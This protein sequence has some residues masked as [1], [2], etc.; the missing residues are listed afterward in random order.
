MPERVASEEDVVV[1]I[2]DF[3]PGIV[4]PK[5]RGPASGGASI[6]AAGAAQP[7]GTQ[8]CLAHVDG[9]IGPA[10]KRMRHRTET[11]PTFTTYRNGSGAAL[12]ASPW[13]ATGHNFN[14]WGSTHRPPE[15]PYRWI[16]ATALHTPGYDGTGGV[17]VDHGIS[18][19]MILATHEFF[20]ARGTSKYY[21]N[22]MFKGWVL[23]SPAG[24]RTLPVDT[25]AGV[26]WQ[27]RFSTVPDYS[28]AGPYAQMRWPTGDLLIGWNT[29]STATPAN[30]QV[31]R[32]LFWRAA[33]YGVDYRPYNGN[34]AWG[35]A[36]TTQQMDWFTWG[37]PDGLTLWATPNR[38]T[39]ASNPL[40]GTSNAVYH[41]FRFVHPSFPFSTA[42][43]DQSNLT[44]G[45]PAHVIR[46]PIFS[47]VAYNPA[48]DIVDD[49]WAGTPPVY[50]DKNLFGGED[51]GVTGLCSV[52]AS[53]LFVTQ[54]N[55]G[56]TVIRGDLDKS[57]ETY[58]PAVPPT[59]T[60]FS[61]PVATRKG[62]VY[63][64]ASGCHVWNEGS[65]A[66]TLSAN[67]PPK[68]WVTDDGNGTYDRAFFSHR[69]GKLGAWGKFVFV[70]NDWFCDIDSG[71]WWRMPDKPNPLT[72]PYQHYE[73]SPDGHLY[74]VPAYQSADSDTLWCRYDM[75]LY[76]DAAGESW[77][78]KSHP[79]P[80][81]LDSRSMICREIKV[82]ASGR[83]SLEFVVEGGDASSTVTFDV[84][85]HPQSYRLDAAVRNRN[86]TRGT[87]W[88]TTLSIVAT[89]DG[90]GPLP[91]VHSVDM[92]FTPRESLP[93]VN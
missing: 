27:H 79:F 7:K 81:L 34:N 35:P 23:S 65:Q 32:T 36:E 59:G 44:F 91:S 5:E 76:E 3:S 33:T 71:A 9:S 58:L 24:D 48:N 21:P 8:G 29:L 69:R 46:T 74:A 43:A 12:T 38:S 39:K 75:D 50:V 83:G 41:V 45:N 64:G 2:K 60:Y 14:Q 93:R 57:Q 30:N 77:S 88:G 80:D 15:A 67:L 86:S 55:G 70:P 47:N 73:C 13:P 63:V 42:P 16:V 20:D 17:T 49:G 82:V 37:D 19:V 22:A 90:N 89:G 11:P 62:I 52:N 85:D 51:Y 4:D 31:T 54:I 72:P 53:T 28:D 87:N 68:F 6:V 84:T 25:P 92:V 78:W 10:F 18:D 56:A 1:S 61:T 66:D 26:G 40:G